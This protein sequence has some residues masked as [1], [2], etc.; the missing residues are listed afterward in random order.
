MVFELGIRETQGRSVGPG[1]LA[2]YLNVGQEELDVPNKSSLPVYCAHVTMRRAWRA[3][4]TGSRSLLLG[5]HSGRRWAVHF[6][7]SLP[8]DAGSI[9]SGF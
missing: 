6:A 3:R 9:V 7:V 1:A 8:G 2:H 5:G 4:F